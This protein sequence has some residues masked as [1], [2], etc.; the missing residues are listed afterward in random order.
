MTILGLAGSLRRGS[1]NRGLIRAAQALAPEGVTVD[2]FDLRALPFFD[3][4]VEMLG[5]PRPVDALKAA[6]AS[7]DAL[8]I[9]TPEYNHGVP[10]VLKN[11]IDWA[12]RPKAASVLARKPVAIVGAGG[13]S[14]TAHAQ[15][16]LRQHL[17]A[18]HADVL[19]EPLVEIARAWEHF[20][21]NGDVAAPEVRV[22]VGL[23]VDALIGRVPATVRV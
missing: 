15:A 3:A 2:G 8:L 5:N 4:D 20:D 16:Q 19:D 6:I 7:A 23:L 1:Y 18:A 13:I 17:A 9:A 21:E 14:G 22:A 10:A 12:S 11:A